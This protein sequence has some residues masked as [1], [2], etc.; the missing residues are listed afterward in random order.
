VST[1][2]TTA[3]SAPADQQLNWLCTCGDHRKCTALRRRA[4]PAEPPSWE[5]GR[6]DEFETD[7]APD[8]GI[9]ADSDA[10]DP[11]QFAAAGEGVGQPTEHD[12]GE[13]GTDAAASRP[14]SGFKPPTD[15]SAMTAGVAAMAPAGPSISSGATLATTTPSTSSSSPS[16]VGFDRLA[17]VGT[18]RVL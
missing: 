9:A 16:A 1:A 5:H 8:K 4:T 3:V 15:R 10:A 13:G 12:G 17:D 11:A 2:S 14:A 18:R 6:H 7:R